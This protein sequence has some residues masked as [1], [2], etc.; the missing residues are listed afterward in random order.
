[1]SSVPRP[2]EIVGVDPSTDELRRHIDTFA[3]SK[4]PV[5]ILGETGTGKEVVAGHIHARSNRPNKPLCIANC[6]SFA[7]ELAASELFGHERGA[8]TGAAAATRGL[9]RAADGGTLFLD[10]I[11]D[12]P[13]QVQTQLLRTIELGEIRPVG[14]EKTIRVN[15]RVIA[16]TNADLKSLI[17]A[18]TFR[19][20]LLQRFTVRVQTR[21]LRER[22]ADIEAL[23]LHFVQWHAGGEGMN[24]NATRICRAAMENLTRYLWPGNVREL[25]Q[26]VKGAL[27]RSGSDGPVELRTEHFVL[28]TEPDSDSDGQE[29]DRT[30]NSLAD[31]GRRILDDLIAGRMQRRSLAAIDESH[32]ELSLSVHIARA[33]VERF[34]GQEAD[35]Q[36]SILFGYAG[37]ES[38]RSF[39]RKLST[40]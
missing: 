34:K 37:A 33:F 39:A 32:P 26:A 11:A 8:F 38:V 28:P 20:D 22:T 19:N 21:P 7:V 18:G 30:V 14:S 27:I 36:A 29:M 10:E 6:G 9:F 12:L 1:M 23:A 5:L 13:R 35:R 16:A 15:V 31:F 25:E 2:R 4:E 17:A 40:R 24:R 3:P